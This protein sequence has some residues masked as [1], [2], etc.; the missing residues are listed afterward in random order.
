MVWTPAQITVNKNCVSK[1]YKYFILFRYK[2]ILL[3]GLKYF[4][5]SHFFRL[6]G[7]CIYSTSIPPDLS[8]LADKKWGCF[9]SLCWILAELPAMRW[10]STQI[11]VCT[12]EVVWL[13]R[14]LPPGCPRMSLGV[15]EAVA[16]GP[17]AALRAAE[18]TQ[19]HLPPLLLHSSQPLFLHRGR[20]ISLPKWK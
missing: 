5:C 18:L 6:S 3:P 15:S 13:Y 10:D 20:R 12:S 2:N 8:Q 17:E 1:C 4:P 19:H 14:I 7:F 9:T 16:P 11:T